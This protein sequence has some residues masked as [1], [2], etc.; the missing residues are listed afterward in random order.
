MRSFDITS[1]YAYVSNW[2]QRKIVSSR[3]F[4]TRRKVRAK[5]YFFGA[6]NFFQKT[7]NMAD[8]RSKICAFLHSNVKY[9]VRN[10]FFASF[11]YQILEFSLVGGFFASI[12][13]NNLNYQKRNAKAVYYCLIILLRMPIGIKNFLHT[14]FSSS[15]K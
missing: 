8:T 11:V 5:R 3:L 12:S 14:N 15:G 13:R 10:I 9:Y 4:S 1:L 7:N 6:K 2:L